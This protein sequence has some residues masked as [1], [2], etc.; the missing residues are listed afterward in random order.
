MLERDMNSSVLDCLWNS[1]SRL[2]C[3]NK[4]TL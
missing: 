3:S 2:S 1:Q 4:N